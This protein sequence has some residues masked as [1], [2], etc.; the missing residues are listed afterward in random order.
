M[1]SDQHAKT[2]TPAAL[3]YPF[4]P[5]TEILVPPRPFTVPTD[6]AFL[7]QYP[8]REKRNHVTAFESGRPRVPNP[9]RRRIEPRE[10][11]TKLRKNKPVQAPVNG[12]I[13]DHVFRYTDPRTLLGLRTT[14]KTFHLTL[15]QEALWKE[16]RENRLPDAPEPPTGLC[17]RRYMDLLEGSGCL[18]CGVRKSKRVQWAFLARFCEKCFKDKT[19]TVNP[20]FPSLL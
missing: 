5:H 11:A 19:M 18:G 13:W 16:C 20:T 10:K 1:A 4:F 14:C 9:K 12:D 8:P 17:E 6:Q 2:P 15:Q 3:H 7:E